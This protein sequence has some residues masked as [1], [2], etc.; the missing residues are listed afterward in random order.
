FGDLD[1]KHG[2][3]DAMAISP[4][5][6]L[7]EAIQKEEPVRKAGVGVGQPDLPEIIVDVEFPLLQCGSRLSDRSRR[8]LV[9]HRFD[10]DDGFW[11]GRQSGPRQDLTWCPRWPC[12]SW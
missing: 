6:R 10:S 5:Q 11:G 12:F 1:V 4:V 3:F 8:D 9:K 7:V 2:D